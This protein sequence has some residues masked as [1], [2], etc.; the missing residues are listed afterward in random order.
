MVIFLQHRTGIGIL[1]EPRG[2]ARDDRTRAACVERGSGISWWRT[3]LFGSSSRGAL[4]LRNTA[5]RL[6]LAQSGLLVSCLRVRLLRGR[7]PVLFQFGEPA[8][9]MDG[10]DSGRHRRRGF[11]PSIFG[12]CPNRRISDRCPRHAI[13]C[14]SRAACG[15]RCVDRAMLGSCVADRGIGDRRRRF[16]D[17]HGN[18]VPSWNPAWGVGILDRRYLLFTLSYAHNDRAESHQLGEEAWRRWGA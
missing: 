5:D 11:L 14:R 6:P 4:V 18:I 7:R 13:C 12:R 3:E 17:R 16:A 2:W 15:G 9:R 10:L 1:T 8:R